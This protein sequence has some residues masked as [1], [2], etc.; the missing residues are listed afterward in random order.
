M[1]FRFNE[2]RAD[3]AVEFFAR[4][5]NHTKGV[6]AGAPFILED[7][8]AD[9]IIRPL[10]G[11]EAWYE[12]QGMWLRRYRKA[13]IELPKK[14]GKSEL[15]SGIALQGVFADGEP[16]PE[17]Y[18]V[19]TTKAQAGIVF[20]VAASMTR[21]NK[22]LD[23]SAKVYASK[24]AHH[25]VLEVPA[26]EGVYKVI[27]G[28]VGTDDGINPSR[29]VLDE[30]HRFKNRDIYDLLDESFA[31][32]TEPLY[33]ILTTAGPADPTHV[34]W[35]L[36]EYARKVAAGLLQ[37]PHLFSYIQSATR[38]EVAGDG[39]LNEDLWRRVNP[40]VSFNPGL[41]DNLRDAALKARESPIKKVG[42]L[43]LR[44]NV[45]LPSSVAS[46]NQL[47]DVALWDRA[48][49]PR[50]D[51]RDRDRFVGIDM[52]ATTDL[53]AAAAVAW[54]EP[55][56]CKT[57]R[58]TAKP[59]VDVE[60][61]FWVPAET[62]EGAKTTWTKD[63]LVQL[64]VWVEQGWIREIP[65]GVIDDD[66][67]KAQIFDWREAGWVE[68]V[69]V[70]PWQ[71]RQLR[72]DLEDAGF[73]VFEHRQWM[74]DMTMSTKLF[75]ELVTD[76]RLHHGGNPVLRWMVDNAVGR[77]DADGN[78]KPDKQKSSGKID[79]VVAAV[80]A[81]TAATINDAGSNVTVELV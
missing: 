74:R 19:A 11:E 54:N 26:T 70:D 31:A 50:V 21:R 15:G 64:R 35:E 45:W 9:D 32:R 43:R 51:L 67:V 63:M 80:M 55:G 10:F 33:V 39:W 66:D 12:D 49:G 16:S 17:V 23:R 18:S 42:F 27:P 6:W 76:G 14:N 28:D 44:L 62:L 46:Q 73:N 72:L 78:L 77:S 3:R 47:V 5:L 1:E 25:G 24:I 69:A 34:A 41:M 13:Y 60:A 75:V 20:N 40:A 52:S 81:L 65:G 8:Q 38:D 79:G 30:L 57:C 48:A 56:E 58:K 36:H 59:C 7:W 61:M 29:A 37:D 71:A 2:E 4:Y 22:Q 68:W 53:T